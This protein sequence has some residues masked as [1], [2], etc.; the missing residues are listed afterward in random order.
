MRE[1]KF[2]EKK[3]LKKVDF[4]SWKSENLTRDWHYQEIPVTG[5]GGLRE[6]Q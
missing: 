2:H 4:F 5:S 3:L 1:L 6:I